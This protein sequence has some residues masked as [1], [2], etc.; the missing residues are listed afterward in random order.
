M[1]ATATPVT[2]PREWTARRRKVVLEH[3]QVLA[4]TLRLADWDIRLDF[5]NPASEDSDAQIFRNDGQKR[6]TVR[7]G[8]AFLTLSADDQRQT[9]VH[10]LVHCHLFALHEVAAAAFKLL[11][12]PARE[13]AATLMNDQ[14]EL[15]TDGLAD[16]IAPLTDPIC[17][18]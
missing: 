4:P 2:P 5:D 9:L 3:V 11:P 6:A 12:E 18:S 14:V 10:E 16:A 13:L 15:A 17:V 8:P 1:T 7:F